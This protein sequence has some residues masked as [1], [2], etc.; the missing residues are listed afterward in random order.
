MQYNAFQGSQARKDQM[1]EPLRAKWAALAIFPLAYLK[2]RTDGGMVSISGALAETQ[3]PECFV[4]RTGLPVE[5]G[6]LCEGLIYSGLEFRP[7]ETA[8]MGFTVD[9]SDT[10]LAF[11]MEWL[12]AIPVGADLG[13]VV[14]RFMATFLARALADDFA[15]AA[16][17]EA[18]VRAAA[19]KIAALWDRDLQGEP[20]SGKEWRAVRAEAMAAS[21]ASVDPMGFAAA[22]MV[23]SLAW[24]VRG[25]ASEF[26]PILQ[27]F[28][29]S[30]VQFMATPHLTDA[31]RD[32]QQRV[33][34]GE[35]EMARAVRDPR[36]AEVP[37]ETLLD[38]LPEAREAML[39]AMQPEVKARLDAAKR[40]ARAETDRELRAHMDTL[41]AL[42]RQSSAA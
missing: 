7:D 17:I 29:K 16:H 39:A 36:F 6:T 1:V 18:P 2:F 22:E 5:L 32:L 26:V 30:W 27:L 15:M 8:P 40:E 3:D 42:I 9:A 24:P 23:E 10:I 38:H 33:L 13:G 28:A 41:L 21:E 12:D 4:E 19:E 11:G 35:R 25:L 14:P 31:D 20:T 37:P 34:L